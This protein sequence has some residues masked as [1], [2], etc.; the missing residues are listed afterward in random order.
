M[1]DLERPADAGAQ[2]TRPVSRRRFLTGLGAG[3]G[4]SL[5]LWHPLGQAVG[6]ALGAA[7]A[8]AMAVVGAA[9]G[10]ITLVRPADQLHVTFTLLGCEVVGDELVPLGGAGTAA[11][12]VT[13]GSQHAVD[14]SVDLGAGDP[15]PVAADA[16]D[17]RGAGPSRVVVPLDGPV[18]FTV[19]GLIGLLSGTPRLDPRATGGA[20]TGAPADDVTAIEVP[21][22]V[23]L[24]PEADGRFL[25]EAGPVEVDGVTELWRLHLGTDD[26][27]GGVDRATATDPANVRAVHGGD[28]ADLVDRPLDQALRADLVEATSDWTSARYPGHEP[29]EARRL[30]LSLHGATADLAG[31]WT[32]PGTTGTL[33]AYAELIASGATLAASVTTRGYLAPWGTPASVLEVTERRFEVAGDGS[34]V[35]VLDRR[36]QLLVAE[37][38]VAYPATDMP[39]DGRRLPFA[40]VQV[41][42][43]SGPTTQGQIT[44]TD[45]GGGT[46]TIDPTK[47]FGLF[48]PDTGEE[49]RF[50]HLAVD[51]AGNE[52]AFACPVFFVTGDVAFATGFAGGTPA[53]AELADLYAEGTVATFVRLRLLLDDQDVALTPEAVPGSGA[54]TKSVVEMT[55]DLDRP[56]TRTQ[57]EMR[58]A[59]QPAFYPAMAT[60]RITDDAL[61]EISGGNGPANVAVSWDPSWLADGLGPA[62]VGNAFLSLASPIELDLGSTD[63]GGLVAPVLPLDTFSQDLG[64]ATADTLSGGSWDPASALGDAKLLGLIPLSDV[65]GVVSLGGLDLGDATQLP[66]L[67]SI[68]LPDQLCRAF[69]WEP[70]LRTLSLA[71]SEVF[72]VTDDLAA[73]GLDDPFDGPSSALVEIKACVA[74]DAT[75]AAS[76]SLDV[77]V[78]NVVVQLPPA[79][80]ALAL[81]LAEVRWSGGDDAPGGLDLDVAGYQFVGTIAFLEPFREFLTTGPIRPSLD[82]DPDAGVDAALR[83]SPPD[84]NIGV[85]RITD[86]WASIELFVPF[87]TGGDKPFTTKFNVGSRPD[88]IGIGVMQFKGTASFALTLRPPPEGIVRFAASLTIGAELAAGGIGVSGAIGFQ[89]GGFIEYDAEAGSDGQVVVGGTFSLYGSISVWAVAAVGVEATL[90]LVYKVGPQELEAIGTVVGWV[91]VLGAQK[92]WELQVS[93]TF[94]L[95]SGAGGGTGGFGF[96]RAALAAATPAGGF[97]DAYDLADWTTYC[98]AFA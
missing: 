70:E 62:N 7:P 40:S 21:A 69:T 87:G 8:G 39:D 83:I 28:E 34:A 84:F 66:G 41:L 52:V 5:V 27:A 37:A 65:L 2:P 11:V 26:G 45:A 67:R 91:M 42:P 61:D 22:D 35:A 19:A 85:L 88:P 46:R 53:L 12:R 36:E 9:T 86:V 32:S 48:D 16:V 73:A 56:T 49:R 4:A 13:F 68:A 14:G 98:G 97:A 55:L 47:I 1:T 25:A 29:L 17:V 92:E 24:S 44:W 38:P 60:A 59:G 63:G 58:A 80:P 71:G 50:D 79:V 74:L 95:S 43:G 89:V 78:R 20:G 93:E 94:D 96:G 54:T 10:T 31:A 77:S 15:A 30:W 75:A 64:V 23:I 3:A 33:V 82:I 18:P 76:T 6:G 81:Q 72:V 51:H 90:E 57:A